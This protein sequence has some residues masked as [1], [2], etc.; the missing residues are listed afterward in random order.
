MYRSFLAAGAAF[1]AL[2]SV[3]P[4][5]AADAAPAAISAPE[6][7]FTEWTLDNGL[8][9]IALPD[10]TTASVTTSVWYEVGSKNDPE[11][12]SGFA[13]LFEH[14]LSRKTE[15]MPYN[16]VNRL[17][18]D[19]G[20][21]R[22][23]STGDDRTNYYETVP[24]KYLETMLWTH[25]ERM[26]R[27]VVDDEVF[28]KERSIVKEELRQR[29]LAPPY[30]RIRL[31]LAENGFDVLPERRPGIGNIDE[32]N[33]ATLADARAFHQA[34][35]G[36]DTAT[37]I[38][39]GN[40]DTANLRTLVDK[41]FAD[42]PRRANPVPVAIAGVE[43]P[44]TSPRTVVATAPN[45]PLPVVGS[46]WKVPA[47]D[48]PDAAALEVLDAVM[49]AGDNSR[50][51]EALVRTGKA[52][53]VSESVNSG[54]DG[55][56]LATFAILNP[57]ADQGEVK[58]ILAGQ[59]ARIRNEPVT[60][61]ELAEAKNTLMASA[62]RR[63]ETVRGR[64]FELG[65]ALVSTGDPRAADVRLA[66]IGKVT[67]ADVQR[68]ARTW[69]KPEAVVDWTYQAGED[70]PASYANPVPMPKFASV[71]PATGEPAKLN[72]E[73]QRQAP[74]API[75]APQVETA[76]LV[77]DKLTNGIPLV[78]AQ[79][80]DVPI[81]TITL[82][83]PGGSATDPRGKAGLASLAAAVADKG[84]PT[85]TAAQ[86]AETLE[87]LGASLGAG[88][89]DDGNFVSLT[90]PT[91][92]LAAA[93]EV[94][95]DIVRNASFPADEVELQRKRTI[96][97]LAVAMKDPGSVAGMV[98][99]RLLYGDAPYGG[100]PT[101]ASLPAITPVDLVAWRKAHWHP[102][103]AKIVVSG[104]ISAADAKA[105]TETLFGDWTSSAPAPAPVADPAGGDQPV[106]TVVVDMPEAGQ[107][108]VL[109]GTR[110]VSRGSDQYWPLQ[111]ANAVLG[112]GS[113]GRLFEEVRT[114]RG[115]SY[116]AYSGFGATADTAVLTASAQTKNETADEV[117]Q[118]ILDQFDKIG[119][120]PLDEETVEKRRLFI[121]GGVQRSLET[122]AG[123]NG[124]VANLMLQGI[125]PTESGMIAQRLAAVTPEAAQAVAKALLPADKATVVVVGNAA[126]FLD[127]LKKVRPDV[128]VIEAKDLDLDSATLVAA[129]G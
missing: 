66:R 18:E 31:V 74:P 43:P 59:I 26:A 70:N 79:T 124:I 63:R 5:V 119:S 82:V 54:E 28:E 2:V 62:L 122:S 34:Y 29:I 128:T 52:V 105:V 27:P 14:I 117:V 1:T 4:A 116:G 68:V 38:V 55:G 111:I 39:A 45:V 19:V 56:Y 94:L 72:D 17:T 126:Q 32:L 9:V 11:G 67:A 110:V 81:A 113:N 10:P 53:Q 57:T 51:Y 46:L 112:S 99:T 98:A 24:A 78:S 89:A 64:A 83:L 35:Y 103:N 69:L 120:G 60:E 86:I 77:E 106:R 75:A 80:G 114:K 47:V 76:R 6:I 48:H 104:G 20:G 88:T 44:R 92:N 30:G 97:S 90:A 15:N 84:T 37:L 23:A 115:L 13:H 93:G 65:E 108:A 50:L 121:G 21:T 25:A 36:P 41:Y 127:D 91:A 107:A 42:I 49:S 123:F 61:A 58:N 40:F 118:V 85:R 129:G 95:A 102:A 12:R 3:M 8:R 16:M 101:V 7:Q 73:A 96:D 22:N 125:A 71:P 87:S 33:S 100:I 109:V